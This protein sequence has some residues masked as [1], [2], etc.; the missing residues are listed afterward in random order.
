[1]GAPLRSRSSFTWAAVMFVVLVLIFL[2]PS[3]CFFRYNILTRVALRLTRAI[4]FKYK[5]AWV[6]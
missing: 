3:G 2:F 5:I 4:K 6:Y 1:M